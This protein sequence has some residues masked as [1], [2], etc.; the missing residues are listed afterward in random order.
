MINTTQLFPNTT[1]IASGSIGSGGSSGSSTS[2]NAFNSYQSFHQNAVWIVLC[3]VSFFL[4]V[5]YPC[6]S[7]PHRRR[8]WLQRLRERRWIQD[9]GDPNDWNSPA[10]RRRQVERRLQQEQERL[11]FQSSRTQDDE[12]REQF[13]L[14]Q[15]QPYSKVRSK[16]AKMRAGRFPYDDAHAP[17][18]QFFISFP[19]FC[20]Q[21]LCKEDISKVDRK[22]GSNKGIHDKPETSP[23][24]ENPP[25]ITNTAIS[26]TR[27]L[28]ESSSDEDG[29]VTKVV[30]SV[31]EDTDEM[32]SI[33][34]AGKTAVDSKDAQNSL[35]RQVP[36]GCAICLCSFG[37][38]EKITWSFNVHCPHVF[39]HDC[40]VHWF[41]TV[42]RKARRRPRPQNL[43]MT[44]D[45]ALDMICKFP[46]LCPCCRQPFCKSQDDD[47]ARENVTSLSTAS[48]SNATT[49]TPTTPTILIPSSHT[50]SETE[51]QA[52]EGASSD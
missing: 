33:P 30:D 27:K 10:F 2:S 34:L 4:L 36:N 21:T 50:F 46:M 44:D 14:V 38:E 23:D 11:Q 15:M 48:A 42:G 28:S 16:Q 19:S 20:C 35:R 31:A 32:V 17:I 52:A 51:G 9:E 37:P 22:F 41:L 18:K 26:T 12:I 39:H 6:L 3:L 29:E 49:T 47:E 7:S 1:S 25:I 40:V 43:E 8:I 45:Q 13:L 24:V 5:C